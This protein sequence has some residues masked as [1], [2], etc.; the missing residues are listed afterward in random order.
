MSGFQISS[1]FKIALT[2][3]AKGRHGRSAGKMVN[4]M[5]SDAEGLQSA[6]QGLWNAWV[7]KSLFP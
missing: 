2:L 3:S 6:V 7:R 1:I 4:L 5:S